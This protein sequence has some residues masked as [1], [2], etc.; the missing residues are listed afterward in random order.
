MRLGI[1]V[2]DNWKFFREI[3][4]DLAAH[5]PVRTFVRPQVRLPLMHERI[6]RLL[7]RL[8]LRAFLRAHDVVFFEWAGQLLA[9]ATQ[10]PPPC[11]IV[12]RLLGYE[13]YHWAPQIDWSRVDRVIV[14][15]DAVKKTL[16]RR[17]PNCLN[18]VAVIHHGVPLRSLPEKPKPFRGQIGTL[19]SLTPR[20]RVYELI[21]ALPA[22]IHAGYDL[23]LHI[24]G[25]RVDRFARDY[26]A[27]ESLPAR[28]GIADRVTFCGYV[29]DKDAWYRGT[30]IF[31]SHSYA[32]TQ[33]VALQE[34]MA[35]GCYC[36][37][38]FWE[39]VEEFM[40]PAYIFGPNEELQGKIAA[41]C[42]MNEEQRRQLRA[43]LRKIV[44]EQ[45]DI[46]QTKGRIRE[47]IEQ[48]AAD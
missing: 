9:E 1:V 22:L 4:E 17:Y 43:P 44:E 7:L 36:L 10:Q 47:V 40:P 15:L 11:R 38:H 27:M 25:E 5:Y 32:E 45:F 24:A 21:L 28:L 35:S 26:A 34:A 20:K 37:A 14:L 31:V 23:H 39:G 12:T 41:Y 18:K 19:C 46:E 16:V 8:R 30:D 48:T 42:E 6:N 3:A 13:L 2:D 29:P 33:H